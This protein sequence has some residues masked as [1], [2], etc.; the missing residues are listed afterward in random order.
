MN[1]VLFYIDFLAYREHG[2]AISG[3]AYSALN[4]GPVPQRWDR[5][6]SAFDDVVKELEVIQD[7]ECVS[8]SAGEKPD[9]SVFSEWE[10]QVID[11]VC[12][13]VGK[14]SSR[15]IS[16]MSH[17]EVAWKDHIGKPESIPFNEAFKLVMM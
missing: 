14:M 2:N 9:M 10:L 4:F 16:K 13:K 5:V 11:S 3:L 17:E 12:N 8:L 1:K 7:Q 15:E 6:Y